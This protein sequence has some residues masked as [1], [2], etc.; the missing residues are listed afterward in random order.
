M[1][2]HY[3]TP[4]LQLLSGLLDTDNLR[5]VRACN[6]TVVKRTSVIVYYVR[7]KMYKKSRKKNSSGIFDL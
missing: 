4:F 1:S 5:C 3:E 2:L 7:R 6:N